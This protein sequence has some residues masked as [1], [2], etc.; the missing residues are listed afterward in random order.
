MGGAGTNTAAIAAGGD[1]PSPAHTAESEE[2]NGSSWTEGNNMNQARVQIGGLG[3]QTA[4]LFV[5]G[6][7]TAVVDTVESYNGTSW[8]ETTELNTGRRSLGSGGTTTAAIVF[9]VV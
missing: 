7:T 5:S 3:T 1:D 9:F 6:A 4:A 2:Y 8:T